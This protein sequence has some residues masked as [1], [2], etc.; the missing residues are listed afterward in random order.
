M[1]Q[2]KA[3]EAAAKTGEERSVVAKMRE[4]VAVKSGNISASSVN[5][6][7]TAKAKFS[8]DYNNK[9]YREVISDA[10]L[11][12]KY[13]ALDNSSRRL[14]AQAYYL[15]G[16][17][18]GCVRYVRSALGDSAGEDVLELARR[19]AFEAHDNA[20]Q[21]WALE[22]LV[23]TTGKPQH[24]SALLRAAERTKGLNDHQTL[25][26]SRLKL[27]TGA[28][29]KPDDYMLLSQIALQL[30]FP[31]EAAT[32]NK[33][34]ID[35]GILKG[36]RVNRLVA[37]TGREQ[38]KQDASMA[39]MEA[40]AKAAPNGDALVKLGETYWGQ[41]KYKE[42]VAAV[43][44]GIKKGVSDKNNALI[45]LGMAEIGAGQKAQAV[46]T[47][48]QVKGSDQWEVDAALWSL[49]ARKG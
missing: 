38:G 33:K 4:Y 27:L 23:A 12:R 36:E 6:A 48:S 2:V 35:A 24:W 8:S 3:A 18:K 15:S 41:G 34:G 39:E 31:H 19:C 49:Y 26:I 47:L 5:S 32:V 13:G 42:A 28:L 44:A 22:A 11:L 17:R 45:R 46:K 14:V 9:R 37:M 21:R 20:G 10:D 40:K 1:D 30:G 7:V 25:D 29:S 43:Q 16:D